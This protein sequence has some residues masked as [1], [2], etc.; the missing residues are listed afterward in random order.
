MERARDLVWAAI[1]EDA[2][3]LQYASEDPYGLNMWHRDLVNGAN[4]LHGVNPG[5]CTGQDLRGDPEIV[6]E[7][8]KR[9]RAASVMLHHVL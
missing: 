5:T 7:A 9:G 6:A 4:L 8:V 3:N 1:Q 2:A